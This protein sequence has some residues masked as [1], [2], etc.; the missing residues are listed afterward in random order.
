MIRI[1]AQ[2]DARFGFQNESRGSSTSV[3]RCL[4]VVLLYQ[5]CPRTVYVLFTARVLVEAASS[6]GSALEQKQTRKGQRDRLHG[7]G[8][9]G[10]ACTFDVDSR[11]PRPQRS[12]LHLGNFQLSLSEQA[13]LPNSTSAATQRHPARCVFWC[14]FLPLDVCLPWSDSPARQRHQQW[15]RHASRSG[16]GR[17]VVCR[18]SGHRR[19]L[20]AA[21]HRGSWRC[22]GEIRSSC[23]GPGWS[24]CCSPSRQTSFKACS[25]AAIA[26]SA[27]AANHAAP[28]STASSRPNHHAPDGTPRA[29]SAAMSSATRRSATRV[30]ACWKPA[31]RFRFQLRTRTL[32][33]VFDCVPVGVDLELLH[34]IWRTCF[35]RTTSP[36]ASVPCPLLAQVSLCSL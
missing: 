9:G 31:F 17:S 8:A 11:F 26:A 3:S 15:C 5:S 32:T 2:K 30:P 22:R 29:S 16:P 36:L 23:G 4:R 34:S 7:A 28:A 27:A 12:R 10:A 20:S 24:A 14:F 1:C 13:R 19:G 6:S 25:V 35:C 18:T 33:P 21:R